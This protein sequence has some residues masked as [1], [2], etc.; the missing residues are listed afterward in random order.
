MKKI[1]IFLCLGIFLVSSNLASAEGIDLTLAQQ[2]IEQVFSDPLEKNLASMTVVGFKFQPISQSQI[3]SV[4][5]STETSRIQ[6]FDEDHQQLLQKWLTE[7]S[8]LFAK[9]EI[10]K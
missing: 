1:L 3:W 2:K 8:A 5:T 6:G 7:T 9:D 10:K 4:K